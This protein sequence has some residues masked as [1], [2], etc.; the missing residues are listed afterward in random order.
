MHV[1]SKKSRMQLLSSRFLSNE[2]P[3]TDLKFKEISLEELTKK[4]K[5]SPKEVDV[6]FAL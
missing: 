5:D 3:N 2:W 4:L 1:R 6:F